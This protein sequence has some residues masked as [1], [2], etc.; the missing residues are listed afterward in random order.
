MIRSVI[1][2]VLVVVAG[3]SNSDLHRVSGQVTFGDGSPVTVGRIV[4]SYDDGSSSWGRVQK[5]GSFRVGTK[6][7]GDGMRGGTF[8]VAVKDAIVPT[9]NGEPGGFK[10]IVHSRFA[11]PATSGLEFTVP[12]QTTWNIVVEKP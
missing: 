11:D 3:C 7:D 1:F 5:D 9:E 4:V 6:I 12:D 10:Q 2:S 8:R